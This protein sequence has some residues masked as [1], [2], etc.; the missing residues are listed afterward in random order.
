[1][2]DLPPIDRIV[3]DTIKKISEICFKWRFALL[4]AFAEAEDQALRQNV[5]APEPKAT[6]DASSAAAPVVSS[7][8]MTAPPQML[9]PIPSCTI[10]LEKWSSILKKVTGLKLA[11]IKLWPH[12]RYPDFRFSGTLGALIDCALSMA[13]V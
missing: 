10:T 12:L 4:R 3:S 9:T 5:A 8:V 6:S 7:F 2:V 11:W 1:V 13:F